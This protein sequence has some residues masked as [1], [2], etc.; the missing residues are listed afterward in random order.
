[1]NGLFREEYNG[2]NEKLY[3]KGYYA[4]NMVEPYND[5][6]EL[7]DRSGKTVIDNLSLAQLEALSELL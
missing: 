3:K 1:M 4:S 2:A 5:E 7:T 6:Y